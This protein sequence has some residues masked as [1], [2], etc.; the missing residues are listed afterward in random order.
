MMPGFSSEALFSCREAFA[1]SISGY[2]L[3]FM[4]SEQIQRKGG[5]CAVIDAVSVRHKEKIDE[6]DGPYYRL[7]RLLGIRYKLELYSVINEIG[8]YPSF[9]NVKPV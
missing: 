3:D 4:F 8:K 5:I 1:R 7:M 2:G 9:A 6:Q